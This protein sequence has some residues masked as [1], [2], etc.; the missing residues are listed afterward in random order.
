MA[1]PTVL[2]V[3]EASAL[4]YRRS[5]RTSVFSAFLGP[6]LYLAAMGLGLGTLVDEGG[7]G[8]ALVGTSYLAFVAPGLLATTAMSVAVAEA[9][10]PVMS[11]IKW[12]NTYGAMLATPLGVTDVALGLLLWIVARLV[13]TVVVF[14]AVVVAFGAT[15]AALDVPAAGLALAVPAAVLTGAAFA[16][17]TL[18]YTA[19]LQREAGLS[20]LQR[21]VVVPLTLFSGAFFPVEQLP[22]VLRP[23][24][25]FTP[26]WHGVELCRALA[27]GAATAG[28]TT[29]G[30]VAYLALWVVVGSFAAVRRF[31]RRLVT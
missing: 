11:G 5:W 15:T 23:V 3:A 12:T 31:R 1:V 20:G 17:P 7:R 9:T 27:L 16:A 8:G 25:V 28:A 19:S 10:W 30:H 29:A 24:V 21:F 26:L 2:R 14:A 13:L 4:A 18:A 22:A 6:A